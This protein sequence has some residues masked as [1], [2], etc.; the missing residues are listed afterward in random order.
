MAD[1]IVTVKIM[2]SDVDTNLEKIKTAAG[3]EIINF[4]GRIVREEIEPV[5]FGL[6]A[7]KI[8]FSYDENKGGTDYIEERILK[9]DGVESVNVV[10]VR[11]A[12]G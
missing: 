7:L 5:A 1:V 9:I 6:K 11:R 8:T 10:D 12:I 3:K 4:K 2:P